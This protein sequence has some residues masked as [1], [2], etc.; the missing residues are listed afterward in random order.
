MGD[1]ADNSSP[2]A[3]AAAAISHMPLRLPMFAFIPG[4]SYGN[5]VNCR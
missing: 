5:S 4:S 1:M 3:A 2:G